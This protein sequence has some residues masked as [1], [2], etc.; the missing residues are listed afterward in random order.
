MNRQNTQT[1]RSA[2]F[3]AILLVILILL[4]IYGLIQG[5]SAFIRWASSQAVNVDPVVVASLITGAGTILG[6]VLIAS[7]NAS[8]PQERAAEEAN[9]GKKSKSTIVSWCL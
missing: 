9:R 1:G 3:G 8:R 2:V 5:S 7:I 4:A 6:S